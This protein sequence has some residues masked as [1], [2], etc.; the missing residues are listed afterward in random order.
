MKISAQYEGIKTSHEQKQSN[1]ELSFRK[2]TLLKKDKR[3]R[4][5]SPKNRDLEETRISMKI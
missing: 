4:T 3:E 5:P 2:K 1:S